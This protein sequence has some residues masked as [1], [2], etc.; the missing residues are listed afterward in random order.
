MKKMVN[1]TTSWDDLERFETTED[2]LALIDGFDGVE[3][4]YF[5][6]DEK[7]IIPKE[8]VIGFH[9]SYYPY[10]FDFWRGDQEAVL[11]ELDNE[12]NIVRYFGG[13]ERSVIVDHFKKDME[14]S[15]RYG[16]EYAV[17]HVSDARIEESFTL[18]Y[19]HGSAEVID[20]TAEILN[21]VLAD[22]DG[23]VA[24]LLENLWQPGLTM[25]EPEVTARLLEKIEYK[26]TGIMLD[27][28]HL[29]HTNLDLKTQEEGLTYIHRQ[30]DRHGELCRYIR[31]MH[32]NQSLTGEYCKKTMA[33]PPKMG[34]TLEERR[35]QMFSHAFAVDGHRPFT[36]PGVEDL[37]HRIAPE[38]LTCEFITDDNKQH[39][40]FLKE[41]KA[42]LPGLF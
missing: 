1:M 41:Q 17:F 7:S 40:G 32:L 21:E 13:R 35:M 3:L 9:M 6:E 18:K 5:G 10:W 20:A 38:Y 34:A 36:C 25:T 16:A 28:G 26:N 12:D 4:M 19:R 24:L 42:A 29:L 15:H 27:T 33:N 31:G 39:S 14:L 22:E 2:M 23:S 8:R 30:L 11:E 37:I